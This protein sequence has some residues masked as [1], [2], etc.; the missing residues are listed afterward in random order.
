MDICVYV[1]M[2]GCVYVVHFRWLFDII[3]IGDII[4]LIHD[5][6]TNITKVTAPTFPRGSCVRRFGQEYSETAS[7]KCQKTEERKNSRKR[8]SRK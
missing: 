5:L 8:I 7:S 6:S 1:Y 4:I 2:Y 3:Y